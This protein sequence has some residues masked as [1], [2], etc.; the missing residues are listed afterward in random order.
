MLF[1]S[2]SP[3]SI[4]HKCKCKCTTS[5]SF[6]TT[7]LLLCK[8]I[9]KERKSEL[10]RCGSGHPIHEKYKCFH[11]TGV[12]LWTFWTY[13]DNKALQTAWRMQ[14]LLSRLSSGSFACFWRTKSNRGVTSRD[15]QQH[16]YNQ[17]WLFQT[18]CNVATSLNFT[19]FLCCSDSPQPT[20]TTP[21]PSSDAPTN[22][23]VP[24]A[25][26]NRVREIWTFVTTPSSMKECMKECTLVR[27]KAS[28]HDSMK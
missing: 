23:T 5:C 16:R 7:T 1:K 3:H 27:W 28:K 25:A 21:L 10:Y 4:L 6:C 19:L 18:K 26:A 13:N 8:V 14:A 9:V 11:Q 22:D 12:L 24:T 17:K 15:R 2:V 20:P